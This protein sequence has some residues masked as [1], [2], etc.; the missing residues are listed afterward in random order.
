M[1][2]TDWIDWSME[3]IMPH[4]GELPMHQILGFE[5][6]DY[7]LTDLGKRAAELGRMQARYAKMLLTGEELG[8]TDDMIVGS[9]IMHREGFLLPQKGPCALSSERHSDVVHQI[10]VFWEALGRKLN[11]DE[12]RANGI[13]PEIFADICSR[14]ARRYSQVEGKIKPGTSRQRDSIVRAMISGLP[15]C[16]FRRVSD[17]RHGR[18]WVSA[19]GDPAIRFKLVGSSIVSRDNPW[20]VAL[21]V[22]NKDLL[23]MATA[24]EASL[25]AEVAAQVVTEREGLEPYYNTFSRT[26]VASSV[27]TIGRHVIESVETAAL[28]HPEAGE[29]FA[30]WCAVQ[31]CEPD[32][33]KEKEVNAEPLTLS[34]VLARNWLRRGHAEALNT[35]ADAQLFPE[36]PQ[37]HRTVDDVTILEFYRDRLAGARCEDEIASLSDLLLPDFDRELL[38]KMRSCLP[39]PLRREAIFEELGLPNWVPPADEPIELCGKQLVIWHDLSG[40]AT[41]QIQGDDAAYHE[42][43]DQ[44]LVSSAGVRVEFVIVLGGHRRIES[45]DV[46]TLKGKLQGPM[47][48]LAL[49]TARARKADQLLPISRGED[50]CVV[51]P[52]MRWTSP[53]AV[54]PVTGKKFR[55]YS[56]FELVTEPAAEGD[57]LIQGK[58]FKPCWKRTKESAQESHEW[59]GRLAARDNEVILRRAKKN[60]GKKEAK[61]SARDLL[62]RLKALAARLKFADSRALSVEIEQLV[63]KKPSNQREELLPGWVQ[64][65]EVMLFNAERA[66]ITD[67][68]LY[69]WLWERLSAAIEAKSEDEQT[70]LMERLFALD[71]WVKLCAGEPNNSA[72]CAAAK[73]HLD[74]ME[75]LLAEVFA[76]V[77]VEE[78]VA[79]KN[80][81]VPL[82]RPP[83][84]PTKKRSGNNSQQP[85]GTTGGGKNNSSRK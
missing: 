76:G 10:D 37:C 66:W 16:L 39:V 12:L 77:Q 20:I 85:A 59:V 5:D 26:V 41:V 14:V 18:L 56:G 11:D 24:V 6:A 43:P 21:P 65:A 78:K 19:F 71:H 35:L 9:V 34:N 33:S 52:R 75:D 81:G 22:G 38:E 28:D 7:N 17:A 13:D 48:T 79:V 63:A 36:Y 74:D 3:Q 83:A 58:L 72:S 70:G 45:S 46:P 8:V 15:D 54:D 50:R 32:G 61:T 57:V 64:S 53:G 42:L 51:V 80:F 68:G 1:T 73:R 49:A 69:T 4:A 40:G 82:S 23:D 47:Q 55:F 62:P 31:T 27:M 29:C 44:G 2:Q 84:A 67:S 30:L 25:F 60:A